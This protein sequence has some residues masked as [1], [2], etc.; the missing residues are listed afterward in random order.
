MHA[1]IVSLERA[2]LVGRS[3]RNQRVVSVHPTKLGRKRLQA[4]TRRVRAVER[5]ALSALNDEEERV[6]REWLAAVAGLNT[7][8]GEDEAKRKETS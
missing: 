6:V 1:S 7:S 5:I 2:G 4:A 8:L 3:A